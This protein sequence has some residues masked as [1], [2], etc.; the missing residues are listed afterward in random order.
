MMR[1]GKSYA[2]LRGRPRVSRAV[3]R[4][5]EERVERVLED[6]ACCWMVALASEDAG[7]QAVGQGEE[8]GDLGAGDAV[9]VDDPGLLG[10]GELGG[11]EVLQGLRVGHAAGGG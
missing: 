6:G 3:V 9:G 7:G 8:C 1:V 4:W 11:E 2:G 5:G 10:G